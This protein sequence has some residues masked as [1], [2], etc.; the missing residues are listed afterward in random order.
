M[1]WWGGT[2]EDVVTGLLLATAFLDKVGDS[3]EIRRK[4]QDLNAKNETSDQSDFLKKAAVSKLKSLQV[5]VASASHREQRKMAA[6]AQDAAANDGRLEELESKLGSAQELFGS[7]IRS[8]EGFSNFTGTFSSETEKKR[9]RR[10]F[11]SACTQRQ[12]PRRSATTWS[13]RGRS[14]LAS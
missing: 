3:A 9:R 5:K 13:K 4:S 1:D 11:G 8:M 10:S 7:V 14:I 12:S 2:E 6:S